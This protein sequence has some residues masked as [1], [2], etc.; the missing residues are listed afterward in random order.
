MG[1]PSG[2]SGTCCTRFIHS[3]AITIPA[4]SPSAAICTTRTRLAPCM[5]LHAARGRNA[6]RKR[7]VISSV[8]RNPLPSATIA[9]PPLTTRRAC[10]TDISVSSGRAARYISS[11]TYCTNGAPS[12]LTTATITPASTIWPRSVLTAQ[13]AK[14]LGPPQAV[15]RGRKKLIVLRIRTSDGTSV[16][17]TAIEKRANGSS[18]K[19]RPTMARSPLNTRNITAPLAIRGHPKCKLCSVMARLSRIR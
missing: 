9:Q 13:A 11:K 16:R 18:P 15:R 2:R 6:I 8:L 4:P 12:R 1:G 17:D 10:A 14:A 7:S 5:T 3:S 19:N